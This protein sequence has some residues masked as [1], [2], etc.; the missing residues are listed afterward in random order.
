MIIIEITIKSWIFD[1]HSVASWNCRRDFNSYMSSGFYPYVWMALKHHFKI[2]TTFTKKVWTFVKLTY[3]HICYQELNQV[4]SRHIALCHFLTVKILYEII[5]IIN[6]TI[7]CFFFFRSTSIPQIHI[8]T[9]VTSC[10]HTHPHPQTEVHHQ[11]RTHQTPS[12]A[13][14]CSKKMF[15]ITLITRIVNVVAWYAMLCYRFCFCQAFWVWCILSEV[16][17]V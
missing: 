5:S 13:K 7:F 6:V 1:V 9:Y 17:R 15:I 11:S 8:Q 3:T 2:S 16:T 12:L 10:V 14:V 4:N